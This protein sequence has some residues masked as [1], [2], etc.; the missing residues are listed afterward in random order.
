MKAFI[1]LVSVLHSVDMKGSYYDTVDDCNSAL[2]VWAADSDARGELARLFYVKP[3]GATAARAPRGD[4]WPM[5]SSKQ[6]WAACTRADLLPPDVLARVEITPSLVPRGPHDIIHFE[7][8]AG[9]LTDQ[10]VA[11]CHAAIA[12]TYTIELDGSFP[13]RRVPALVGDMTGRE[14]VSTV[15]ARAGLDAPPTLYAKMDQAH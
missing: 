12:P 5:A 9:L 2:E 1:L 14:A 15:F 13:R 3:T 11:I 7:L 10:I 8:P 4:S 6:S